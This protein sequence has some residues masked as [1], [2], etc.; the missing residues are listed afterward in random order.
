MCKTITRT[1][2]IKADSDAAQNTV[3]EINVP[4]AP[5]IRTAAKM[6]LP[7]CW[8]LI[9]L[10]WRSTG[11]ESEAAAKLVRHGDVLLF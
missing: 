6:I 9:K 8:K 2:S 4:I 11:C 5:A 7:N 10:Q 3:R 1:N